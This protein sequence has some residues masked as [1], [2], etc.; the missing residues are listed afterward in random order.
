MNMESMTPLKFLLVLWKRRMWF[1][2]PILV[3]V[4]LG[5]GAA[6][7]LPPTY[8][9]STLIL[10]EPQKVPSEYVKTTVTT[11]ME[12]RLKT[13]EQ[14]IT[15]REN[16]ERIIEELDL[17]TELRLGG[18]SMQKVTRTARRN[19]TVEV[20][21]S[22]VFRVFFKGKNPDLVARTANRLAELFIQENLRLREKQASGTSA[23]LEIEKRE[24]R[25]ALEEQEAMIAT[26]KR[27]FIGQL[28]EQ[29]DTIILTIEQLQH[30]LE[31]NHD[32]IERA[33]LRRLYL[34]RQSAEE[35]AENVINPA[36]RLE[37]LRAEL[38]E[39]ESRFTER[40]PDVVKIKEEIYRLEAAEAR[41]ADDVT[42][43]VPVRVR[44]AQQLEMNALALEVKQLQAEQTRIVED[45]AIYEKRLENIPRIEQELLSLTRDYQNVQ[46]S[47]TSILEKLTEARLAEDMERRQQ[48][49]QFTI[50]E[51]AIA[52]KDAHGPDPDLLLAIGL[53]FGCGCGL[54]LAFLREMTDQ[55]YLD[56][57]SLTA[58]FPA[59]PLLA[60][61]PVMIP[62]RLP[63]KIRLE[64]R[65]RK[66]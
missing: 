20:T 8:R 44:P 29:R 50:L 4:G 36:T 63:K 57:A 45:R 49:E 15:N 27:R 18:A 24:T 19:L 7:V 58:D 28:P 12:E 55:T 62:R 56:G 60:A 46:R 22:T 9:A 53:V 65:S 41:R 10:V 6:E 23:F 42:E 48:S 3:G 5:L 54:G 13:I 30:K 17:Y 11:S 32:A 35:V 1:V 2:L 31:M 39:A 59:I 47:Y 64:G 38:A 66:K 40:H 16:L 61:I 43:P 25:E 52:P 21:G 37:I 33:E 51:K 14:Q 34:Q 26:F